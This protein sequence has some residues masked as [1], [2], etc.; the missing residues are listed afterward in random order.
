MIIL[1]SKKILFV[2]ISKSAGMTVAHHLANISSRNDVFLNGPNVSVVGNKFAQYWLNK[3][4]HLKYTLGHSPFILKH[5][6]YSE[7]YSRYPRECEEYTSFAVIR[8]PYDRAKSIFNY[9]YNINFFHAIN[10]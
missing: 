6:L 5:A 3:K 7:I 10:H 9:I 8:D 2:H 1:H 4:R